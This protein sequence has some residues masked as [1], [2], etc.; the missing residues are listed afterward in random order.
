MYDHAVK[1]AKRCETRDTVRSFGQMR[2]PGLSQQVALQV[3]DD[4]AVGLAE[5][6]TGGVLR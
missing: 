6:A 1:H 5:V 2:W 3:A 4:P